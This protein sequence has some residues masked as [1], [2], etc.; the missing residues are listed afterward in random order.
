MSVRALALPRNA[1]RFCVADKSQDSPKKS[2][3][4]NRTSRVGGCRCTNRPT[5]LVVHLDNAVCGYNYRA[6]L[7]ALNV[8]RFTGSGV[9]HVPKR[10]AVLCGMQVLRFPKAKSRAWAVQRPAFSPTPRQS[11]PAALL[12]FG[13]GE[14]RAPPQCTRSVGQP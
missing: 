3:G 2:P 12:L 13:V 8:E 6:E 1:T 4:E 11:K 10:H 7:M 9:W 5:R 14:K